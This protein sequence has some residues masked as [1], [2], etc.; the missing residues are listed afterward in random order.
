MKFTVK[1][2]ILYNGPCFSCGNKINVTLTCLN[3]ILSGSFTRVNSQK[4]EKGVLEASL[5]IKY[6]H[7][8][9]LKIFTYN[10]KFI[11]SDQNGLNKYLNEYK[12]FLRSECKKCRGVIISNA[13]EFDP[14]GFIKPISLNRELFD[15]NDK[16]TDY[17]ITTEYD[18]NQ[19]HINIFT[20]HKAMELVIPCL[21]LYK[22]KTKEKLINK[23]KTYIL[24]S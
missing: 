22:F 18:I 3:N 9:T 24:F 23:L 20:D 14:R 2:F 12:L 8:L 4:L 19:T 16:N 1:D 7:N 5:R 13:L 6:S 21:P 11:V 10:N 15:V 17:L